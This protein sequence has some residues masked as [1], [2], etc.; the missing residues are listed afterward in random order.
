MTAR[1]LTLGLVALLFISATADA[2]RK[3]R[4]AKERRA[5]ERARAERLVLATSE[6]DEASLLDIGIQTF[7]LGVADVPIEDG[8]KDLW[9]ANPEIRRSEAVFMAHQLKRTLASSGFWGAVRVVPLG[10]QGLDLILSG[11][12]VRSTPK[13]LVLAVELVDATGQ[14][15]HRGRYRNELGKHAYPER[16]EGVPRHEPHQVVYD[17]IANALSAEL[18]RHPRSERLRIREVAELR[19]AAELAPDLFGNYLQVDRRGGWAPVRLPAE[20]DPMVDRMRRIR[21]RDHLVVDTLDEHYAGFA[22][23]MDLPYW[24]WRAYSHEEFLA[25]KKIRRKARTRKFFGGLL[26]AGGILGEAAG[27][28]DAAVLG[29]AMV[30]QSGIGKGKE[31]KIHREALGELATSFHSEVS[32]LRVEV[33]GRTL[34]LEG[35]AD[36]QYAQWRGLLQRIFEEESGLGQVEQEQQQEL[37]TRPSYPRR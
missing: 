5:Q 37:L 16:V 3:K 15:W 14:V 12:I 22:D 18:S 8:S 9:R 33:E 10:T 30:L 21:Q 11:E 28:E 4:R 6:I 31:A 20:G 2:G 13:D 29:G 1:S 23:A 19:F 7:D 34:Q 17:R 36:Q 24:D 35:T 27:L 32:P 25:W 26:I